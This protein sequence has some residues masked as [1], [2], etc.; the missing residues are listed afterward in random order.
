MADATHIAKGSTYLV[1]QSI[2]D[3]VIRA[4]AFGFIARTLTQ[5]EMG[6]RVALSL[7]AGVASLLADIGFS[8]ALT[9][10]IAEQRGK[11][12]EYS[13]FLFSGVL[14][15]T[16][17]ASFATIVCALVASQLSQLLLK[18]A[19][20]AVL[21][22]LLSIYILFFCLNITMSS[23]L[24][25]LNKIRETAVF[26]VVLT[27]VAQISAVALLS[28][29]YG[30]IGLVVGWILGQLTY[31]IASTLVVAKGKHFRT[32]SIQEIAPFLKTLVKFS[33]PLFLTNAIAFAYGSFDV[34]LLLAYLPL[35]E[36]AVYNVALLAFSVLYVI[37][38]ALNTTLFPYF[39]EQY[40]GNKHENIV[41]GVRAATRYISFLY[42]PLALGLAITANPAHAC[43]GVK[44][45]Q[46]FAIDR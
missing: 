16:S 17:T 30:L 29:G 40:G 1:T 7:V 22:Q 33:W 43:I 10:Y 4:V 13:P 28:F 44:M 19:D 8:S 45:S 42:L 26:N 9:K 14:A 31:L 25:G 37:P 38:S 35:S 27:L 36:V 15:K 11:N 18:S 23:I 24:L 3:A 20:Y 21:F 6:M 5:T 34:A 41:I 2:V 46:P 12:A 39:S 32:H